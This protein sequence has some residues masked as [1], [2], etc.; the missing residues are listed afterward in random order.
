MHVFTFELFSRQLLLTMLCT[1]LG[2]RYVF[3]WGWYSFRTSFRKECHSARHFCQE[4][5]GLLEEI[6][7]NRPNYD[8]YNWNASLPE[9]TAWSQSIAQILS[10]NIYFQSLFLTNHSNNS[11]Y[12]RT[13]SQLC[14]FL[15]VE[16]LEGNTVMRCTRKV[17]ICVHFEVWRG[18]RLVTVS[19]STSASALR[20]TTEQM[21]F[22]CV[23]KSRLLG[24]TERHN[25]IW[26]RRGILIVSVRLDKQ[27]GS[28]VAVLFFC[29]SGRSHVW[30]SC[31]NSLW[32]APARA[33]PGMSH[34]METVALTQDLLE[35]LC[36][37]VGLGMS[38]DPWRKRWNLWLR[39]GEV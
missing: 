33:I 19:I 4:C 28:A 9:S 17:D 24:L 30:A 27:T 12:V 8:S 15:Y 14:L 21:F 39:G 36:C 31:K 22:P 20:E 35:R 3:I 7:L 25:S 5:V 16:T 10:H 38:E 29:D 1:K 11:I 34:S 32:S 2:F 13:L 23:S 26:T 6:T 18:H 37:T